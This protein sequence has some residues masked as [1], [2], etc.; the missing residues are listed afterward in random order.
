MQVGST[1]TAGLGASLNSK[2][3]FGST[4]FGPSVSGAGV[5]NDLLA[6]MNTRIA[7]PLPEGSY[8]FL[9]QATGSAVTYSMIFNVTGPAD[10]TP[11]D[12]NGDQDVNGDDLE[13]WREYYGSDF[14]ADADNDFDVD[15]GDFLIWQRNLGSAPPV[16]IPE[17]TTIKLLLWGAA[18]CFPGRFRR[19]LSPDPQR[20]ARTHLRP[21]A[22]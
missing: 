19:I 6:K 13:E 20:R 7:P 1:W 11:G 22:H 16:G 14:R 4:S 15:G 18:A 17:A 10:W 2:Q 9:F 3:L 8:V 21:I 12:F 5:G